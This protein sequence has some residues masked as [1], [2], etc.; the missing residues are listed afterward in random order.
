MATNVGF[1]AADPDDGLRRRFSEGP[2]PSCDT[3]GAGSSDAVVVDGRRARRL[4]T[5]AKSFMRGACCFLACFFRFCFTV[6]MES[7][8]S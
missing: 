3:A 6:E 5:K 1:R 2:L 7:V 8:I 4:T